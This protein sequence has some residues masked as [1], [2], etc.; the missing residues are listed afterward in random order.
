MST[1]KEDTASCT[2]VRST[3]TKNIIST[4]IILIKIV[5]KILSISLNDKEAPY[6]ESLVELAIL[7]ISKKVPQNAPL[8]ERPPRIE[9]VTKLFL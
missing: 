4:R 3:T 8:L 9:Y 7:Q 1:N 2:T 5:T 6:I